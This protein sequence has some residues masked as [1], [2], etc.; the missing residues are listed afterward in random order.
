MVF[1]PF[2][3]VFMQRSVTLHL[4]L[5]LDLGPPTGSTVKLHGG[6]SQTTTTSSKF[7]QKKSQKKPPKP[8]ARTRERPFPLEFRA[9]IRR[10]LRHSQVA[11]SSRRRHAL[12]RASRQ[13]AQSRARRRSGEVASRASRIHRASHFWGGPSCNLS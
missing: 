1:I 4:S 11:A 2:D 3:M 6:H 12:L 10:A 5:S 13:P 8:L 9:C 7:K